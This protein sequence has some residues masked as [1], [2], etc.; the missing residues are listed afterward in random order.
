M[1]FKRD[2]FRAELKTGFLVSESMK[3]VWASSIECLLDIAEFCEEHHLRWFA[4]FGTLLGAVRH[5]GFIPWDDD[6][7]IALFREDYEYL[8]KNA[9]TFLPANYKM[10][11]PSLSYVKGLDILR[12]C[13]TDDVCTEGSFLKKYH[14]CPYLIGVDIY[15]IDNCSKNREIDQ[16][17]CDIL[18]LIGR[19]MTIDEEI[20]SP[21]EDDL[22]E[23]SEIME[24]LS[25]I[26]GREFSGTDNKVHRELMKYYDEICRFSNGEETDECT[27]YRNHRFQS[28]A[29]YSKKIFEKTVKLPFENIAVD[30][31]AGFDEA[32][33]KMY[34]DYLKLVKS[35]ATGHEYGFEDQ[36]ERLYEMMGFLL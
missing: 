27:I 11:D 35:N 25:G 31:P 15:P 34:G 9:M 29:V 4:M 7:D 30:A 16:S 1:Y 24:I 32:L 8:R 19:V 13:N 20:I 33:K 21:T 12:I 17:I 26:S 36:E 14:G 18:N 23:K 5:H 2:F 10:L 3:K 28:G 6:V 22:A